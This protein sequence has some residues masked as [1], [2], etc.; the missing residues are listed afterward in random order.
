[1]TD[2]LAKLRSCALSRL[3]ELKETTGTH[4]AWTQV[5]GGDKGKWPWLDLAAKK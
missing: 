5:D 1:M 3:D 4:P 2:G